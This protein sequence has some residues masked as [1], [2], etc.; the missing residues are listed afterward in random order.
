MLLDVRCA[1]ELSISQTQCRNNHEWWRYRALLMCGQFQETLCAPLT[2]VI[3][4]SVML[5]MIKAKRL[6]NAKLSC[7]K[8]QQ[9]PK[10]DLPSQKI[11]TLTRQCVRLLCLKSHQ[12]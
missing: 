12:T 3:C 1:G 8:T 11:S 6:N 9:A 4:Y 10:A 7:Q 5:Q 2:N